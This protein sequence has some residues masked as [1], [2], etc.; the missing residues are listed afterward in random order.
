MTPVRVSAL[1]LAREDLRS[2]PRQTF[3]LGALCAFLVALAPLAAVSIGGD[4]GL[5]DFLL[6]LWVVAQLAVAV[7]V[8]ARVAAARRSRFVDSL[9]TTPL[10]QRS[11]IAGQAL[12]GLALAALLLLPLLPFILVQ[13]ALVGVPASLPAVL[14]AG[15]GMGLFAVAF[16][17]FCGVVVGDAGPGA[18]AGIAGGVGFLSFLAFLF[19]GMATNAPVSAAQQALLRATSASPLTLAADAAGIDVFGASAAAAWRPLVGLAALVVG[20]AAAAWIAYTRFQ[21]PVGWE[22]RAGRALLA[23][24]VAAAVLAPVATAETSFR[25]AEDD[26]SFVFQ[27]GAHTQIGFVEPGGAITD[28]AFTFYALYDR[29]A[30]VV[31]EPVA[32]DVL[33]LL[34]VAEGASVRGVVIQ[35]VGDDTLR[36]VE[37]GRLEVPSGAPDGRARASEGFGDVPESAPLRPVY[38]VPVVVEATKANAL[39]DSASIVSIDTTFLADGRPVESHARIVLRADLPHARVA[40]LAAGAP[41]PL[42]AIGALVTRKLRTR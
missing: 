2:L 6:F 34:Q 23:A 36:V 21:S 10:T 26:G 24:L 32:L 18:A 9:Y 28:E 38:R 29:D 42:V 5:R 4:D 1:R 30:L 7:V 16:G 20:L 40:L 19:H 13:V 11:W 3:G 8:A 27:P 17:L 33:V 31:G 39:T 41:L 12:V 25:E 35:V 14:A 22:P 15:V 37:G